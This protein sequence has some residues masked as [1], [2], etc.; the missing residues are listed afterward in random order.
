MPRSSLL[1]ACRR[2]TSPSSSSRRFRSTKYP[3]FKSVHVNRHGV[4]RWRF[5]VKVYTG[6][7]RKALLNSI[8]VK[9]YCFDVKSFPVLTSPCPDGQM[10]KSESFTSGFGEVNVALKNAGKHKSQLVTGSSGLGNA[11]VARRTFELKAKGSKITGTATWQDTTSYSENV[12]TGFD[13][14]DALNCKKTVTPSPRNARPGVHHHGHDH[15]LAH[16][17][18]RAR[19]SARASGGPAQREPLGHQR[20]VIVPSA[21]SAN[22]LAQVR[23]CSSGWKR[24]GGGACRPRG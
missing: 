18:P 12:A 24:C 3:V 5:V 8:K 9:G 17:V 20:R 23:R 19:R 13:K 10:K 14:D 1:L 2:S 11:T 16:V 6:T 15:H 4:R 21:I 7:R 22:T